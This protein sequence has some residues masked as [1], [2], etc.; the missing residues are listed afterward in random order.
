MAEHTH[1]WKFVNTSYQYTWLYRKDWSAAF[2]KT[3]LNQA[4]CKQNH[5]GQKRRRTGD[6][7]QE[8][9]MQAAAFSAVYYYTLSKNGVGIGKSSG[10][11]EVQ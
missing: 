7:V 8:L 9:D 3:L 10:G 1:K 4:L 2:E 5:D 11:G 6:K